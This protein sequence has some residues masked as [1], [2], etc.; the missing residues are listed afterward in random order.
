MKTIDLFGHFEWRKTSFLRAACAE[1]HKEI[2]RQSGS[3][4]GN[5]GHRPTGN[6][7]TAFTANGSS[8]VVRM[9]D[10]VFRQFRIAEQSRYR[11]LIA[12][13]K[14]SGLRGVK[15]KADIN[16]RNRWIWDAGA[17]DHFTDKPELLN[18]SLPCQ[19]SKVKRQHLRT[20]RNLGVMMLLVL[21]A[22]GCQPQSNS[23]DQ[24]SVCVYADEQ[25]ASKCADGQLAWFA[26]NAW[27][28][29][30]LPLMA[31][32]KYCDFRHQVVQNNSGVVCVFTQR[33][34]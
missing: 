27:G 10:S 34:N 8:N 5:R 29:E 24:S 20:V 26:P 21:F 6:I 14:G 23:I 4:Y 7:S 18:P 3:S 28:N 25:E 15:R 31:A 19:T 9:P 13:T 1:T 12:T 22:S 16:S 17:F 30:Q 32:A 11:G 33:T 2:A